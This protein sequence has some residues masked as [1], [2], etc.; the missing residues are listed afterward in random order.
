MHL[1][2]R[3]PLGFIVILAISKT[4]VIDGSAGHSYTM[5]YSNWLSRR[6]SIE[7]H[8]TVLVMGKERMYVR[9]VDVYVTCTRTHHDINVSSS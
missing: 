5:R 9:N 1:P 2:T 3:C 6:Y 7:T 4:V 8:G